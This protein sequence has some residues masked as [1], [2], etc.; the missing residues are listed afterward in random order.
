MR[1]K[2]PFGLLISA[3]LAGCSQGPTPDVKL[4]PDGGPKESEQIKAAC[5]LILNAN[6]LSHYREGLYLLNEPLKRAESEADPKDRDFVL[7]QAHLADAEL[8]EVDASTYRPLDAHHLEATF[9]FRDA[10]RALTVPDL[11]PLEQAREAFGW[12]ARRVLLHE[13]ADDWLPPA[14]VLRRGHGGARDRAFV[15]L[16][17]LRQLQIEG[18]ILAVDPL[19]DP[20]TP[21]LVGVLIKGRGKN[22]KTEMAL[23]DPRLGVPVIGPAGK[24]VATLAQV[25][26]QPELLK[27]SEIAPEIIA[28][29]KIYLACPL[30]AL[31]PRMKF[32]QDQNRLADPERPALFVNLRVLH[33]AVV[34]AAGPGREVAVWNAPA[35]EKGPPPP[36]P[37]RAMRLF[38]PADEGGVD[39]TKRREQLQ[40]HMVPIDAVRQQY[41]KWKLLQFLPPQAIPR[42]GYFTQEL[43]QKFYVEPEELFLRGEYVKCL[44][45]V[46]RIEDALIADEFKE[47]LEEEEFL[48]LVGGWREHVKRAYA[49]SHKGDGG[50]VDALWNEDQYILNLLDVSSEIP[51]N[52]YRKKALSEILINGCKEPLGQQVGYLVASCWHEKAHAYTARASFMEASGKGKATRGDAISAWKTAYGAWTQFLGRHGLSPPVL[53]KRLED[54]RERRKQKDLESVVLLWEFLH[55]DMHAW[56]EARLNLAEVHQQQG[57]RAGASLTLDVLVR[58]LDS[59]EKNAERSKEFATDA[60]AVKQVPQSNLPR[61]ME[62]LERD[63]DARGPIH[64]LRASIA[65]R[66]QE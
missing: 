61:R 38:L 45:R 56:F 33:Q 6:Q 29:L 20:F 62:M 22:A 16:E 28:K 1:L 60:E 30:S 66:R 53:R 55:A 36:S 31:A 7:H 9:L 65:L 39:R 57:N 59:L 8:E 37:L 50:R 54:I 40:Y 2:F 32:V 63:W 3:A 11:P 44:E 43:F 23:F 12:V 52:H 21:L 13:Q 51:L 58:D 35:S 48:K 34:D 49:D 26:E 4:K 10:A 47:P 19:D 42:F 41:Y 17:V 18:C 64:W 27:K 15:F 5:E 46:R 14:Q 25:A 24:G